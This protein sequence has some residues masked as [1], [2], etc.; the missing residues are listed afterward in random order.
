MS[1][2]WPA[3]A[4]VVLCLSA[5]GA[6]DQAH[7]V[8]VNDRGVQTRI[9]GQ[10]APAHTIGLTGLSHQVEL[11]T[12]KVNYTLHYAACQDP[13][14]PKA[15][16][17][18]EGYVGMS[19][20]TTANWY[21]GGFF[22]LQIDG[23][24]IGKTMIHSLTV[25]SVADRGFADFVFD[26]PQ[27]IV[28]LRFVGRLGDDA[29]FAQAL[30]EPKQEIK[31]LRLITRCYPSAFVS[32]SDRHV[33]TA[34]RDLKQGEKAD[35]DLATEYWTLYYDSL[36][37]AGYS[38]PNYVGAGPCSMLWI[39]SQTQAAGFTVGGYGI[40][41]TFT[42]K[43]I[44][45]DFRFIF[46]DH[47][48]AKNA[49]AM[50]ELKARAPALLKDLATFD[51]TDPSLAGWDL[52]T[53]QQELQKLLAQVPEDKTSVAQ[54][55]ERAAKLTACLKLVQTGGTGK[56]MAE[57]EAAQLIGAWEQGLPELRLQALLREL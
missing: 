55:Q 25:R 48:G 1:R 54:Y 3:L 18:G 13:K 9:I 37:E 28:R 4:L 41:T 56:I 47:S 10:G 43:P 44:L 26:T 35:L 36:Y 24:S 46:F 2:C 6:Q 32:N 31:A 14:D 45:R 30:L 22:D 27:A 34:T 19:A 33:Q 57:A 39:P 40:D 21:H 29:L 5:A 52:P 15:A 16:I 42:L 53:R 20:P 23:Q 50:A 7:S 12:G 51:F 17:P 11:N 8:I 49:A 38:G